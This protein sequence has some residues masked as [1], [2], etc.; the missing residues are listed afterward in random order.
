VLAIPL[1]TAAL[2]GHALAPLA[3][4]ERLLWL[5]IGLVILVPIAAAG[6]LAVWLEAAAFVA[7]AGL[8]L[9]HGLAARSMVPA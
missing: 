2:V 4:I 8:L 7:G 9:R 3:M 6:Q 1:I 5:G